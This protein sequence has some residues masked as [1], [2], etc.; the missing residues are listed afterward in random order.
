MSQSNHV[1]SGWR[2]HCGVEV[3]ELS[4]NKQHPLFLSRGHRD[5][6]PELLEIESVVF[7]DGIEEIKL[8]VG[9]PRPVTC[10]L[11]LLLPPGLKP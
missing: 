8:G 1:A 6:V 9:T 7:V 10:D 5:R 11:A 3:T 2:I 4:T